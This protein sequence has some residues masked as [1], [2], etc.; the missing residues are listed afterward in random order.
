MHTIE[1][2][3]N[4]RHLYISSEDERSPQYGYENSEV[5]FTDRI[6]NFVIHPQWDYFGCETLYLKILFAHYEKHYAIIEL[7]GEWNDVLNNDIM[8]LKRQ[9]AE[10]L[11]E[12]GINKFILIGENVLN[13]HA[14]LTD[15][16]EEWF[17]E[18]DDGWIV[19]LNFR[20]HVLSEISGY[21]IDHFTVSGG[22]LDDMPWRKQ[23]PQHLFNKVDSIVSRR[24]Q[25]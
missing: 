1:P 10:P 3:Y 23:L 6:Y 11:M 25:L 18:V 16:Y 22:E 8:F 15:Y 7:I 24:L 2:Y 20:P 21:G 5:H 19:T 13:F 9:I 17:D 14:D 12:E 4:W